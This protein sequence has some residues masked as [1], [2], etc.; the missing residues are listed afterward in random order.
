MY[1]LNTILTNDKGHFHDFMN[2]L[3]TFFVLLSYYLRSYFM[4]L[5]CLIV[6]M[7][8]RLPS[9]GCERLLTLS[10]LHHNSAGVLKY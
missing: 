6:L 2:F 10:C 7:F 3:S 4:S 8:D 5:P 9:T 1:I